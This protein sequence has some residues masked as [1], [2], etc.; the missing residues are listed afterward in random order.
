MWKS[1]QKHAR[2]VKYWLLMPGIPSA[3]LAKTVLL[4]MANSTAWIF[5][6][7]NDCTP[8][9]FYPPLAVHRCL[10]WW[11]TSLE[12]ELCIVT[13]AVL[14]VVGGPSA[15]VVGRNSTR[16]AHAALWMSFI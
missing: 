10:S 9:V 15:S 3:L 5:N 2:L 6:L 13:L 11:H 14:S 8:S 12:K 7:V 16:G 4:E 1:F